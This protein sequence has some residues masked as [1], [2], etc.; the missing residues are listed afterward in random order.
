MLQR[1]TDRCRTLNDSYVIRSSYEDDDVIETSSGEAD[2]HHRLFGYSSWGTE[3]SKGTLAW[4][5]IAAVVGGMCVVMLVFGLA[6]FAH[7]ISS[8]FHRGRH[9]RV[10]RGRSPTASQEGA[11]QW[12]VQPR[13]TAVVGAEK[14]GTEV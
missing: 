12:V 1:V 5:V 11:A 10:G 9:D 3:E 14:Y 6:V 2:V 7:R 13:T 8:M 4:V